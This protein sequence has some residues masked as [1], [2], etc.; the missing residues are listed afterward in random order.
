MNYG[1]ATAMKIRYFMSEAC[2]SFWRNSFMSIASI[3]TVALSFFI[4]GIFAI[5]VANLDNFADNL[6][7]QVQISVYLK[8]G[9]TTEQ[10]MGVGKRLK[11]LPE[12]RQ[13]KFTNK[14]QAMT[15]LKERMKDQPGILEALEGK[16]PLPTSYEI[17]FTQAG[18]VKKAAQIVATYP[19]VESSHY[20]Q[21]IIEQLLNITRV[22]RWGGMALIVLLTVATL[23]IISNTIRLTVFARRKEIGIMKY[24]GATNWFIRWPFLL[25][26]LLLGFI[27][28]VIADAALVQFYRF[29]TSEIHHS[30][31]FLPLVGMNPFMYQVGI[32]LLL[33]SMIIG[34]VGSTISLKRYM[35]V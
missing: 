7:N 12:V 28:G 2:K 35:K 13:I 20:G 9:L 11:A 8:D 16:N 14:D 15:E 30:L 18:A 31:A 32:G 19:E 5:M 4:L 33:L 23:F 24:V 1:G 22:I 26:G 29:V 34:A 6:E 21:E 17:T 27:G 3:V 10:V 25:E